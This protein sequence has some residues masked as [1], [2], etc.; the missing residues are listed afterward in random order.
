M[1]EPFNSRFDCLLLLYGGRYGG[2]RNSCYLLQS[3]SSGLVNVV[4][5]Y[6]VS[7]DPIHRVVHHLLPVF[8]SNIDKR[9][10]SKLCKPGFFWLVEVVA[11]LVASQP[12]G[13]LL[14]CCFFIVWRDETPG[15]RHKRDVC[16]GFDS[17]II[18][19]FRIG[20]V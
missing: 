6:G 14:N 1:S 15:C 19:I 3:Q 7:S 5:T 10:A 2:Y 4:Q 12:I 20:V 13:S 16:K 9:D 17:W 11:R 18:K 8:R